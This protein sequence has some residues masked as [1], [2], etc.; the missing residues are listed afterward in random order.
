MNPFRNESFVKPEYPY[1]STSLTFGKWTTESERSHMGT[2][3]PRNLMPN[4]AIAR[5][6]LREHC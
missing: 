2:V 1:L 3:L 4:D 6:L 5:Q